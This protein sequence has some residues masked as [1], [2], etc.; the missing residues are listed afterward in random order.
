MKVFFVSKRLAFGSAVT[1]WGH[2]EKLRSVGITHVINLRWSQNNAKVRQFDHIWLR[3]HDDKKPRPRW[4][5]RLALKF[6]K[7]ARKDPHAKV[8]VMCH[9]GQCRSASLVYFFLRASGK[10]R[11]KAEHKIISA[12]RTARVVPAYRDSGHEYLR[13]RKHS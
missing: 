10:N 5:Y 9:H 12:R 1:S 6:Y 7:R 4:F 3:F 13:R 2:V 11:S 8:F